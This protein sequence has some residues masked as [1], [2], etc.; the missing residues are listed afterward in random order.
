MLY[1][2]LLNVVKK[3]QETALAEP[4][5]YQIALKGIEP[6]VTHGHIDVHESRTTTS[7]P[8]NPWDWNNYERL[9]AL[10]C[11]SFHF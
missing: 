1:C 10:R 11:M 3:A 7:S 4:S 5:S 8:P 6:R 9:P 2:F